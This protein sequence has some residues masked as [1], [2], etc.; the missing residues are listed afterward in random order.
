MDLS[1]DLWRNGWQNTDSPGPDTHTHT[2]KAIGT[3]RQAAASIMGN[4]M[5]MIYG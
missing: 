5:E 1:L 2:H 4:L 3:D